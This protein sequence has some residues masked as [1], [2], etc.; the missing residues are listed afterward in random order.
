MNEK[1][2]TPPEKHHPID[3]HKMRMPQE[4]LMAVHHTHTGVILGVLILVL[5]LIF[6][7]LVLWGRTLQTQVPVVEKTPIVNREPET[8]RSVADVQ[9]L[10]TTS[11]SDE[12]SAIEAD[13]S[14]TNLDSLTTDLNQ[15]DRELN[16]ATVTP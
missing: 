16:A 1:N 5:F 4:N 6:A 12:L 15:A 10:Q 11:P 3:V 2:I 14:S 8:P 9:I 7:G 13:L